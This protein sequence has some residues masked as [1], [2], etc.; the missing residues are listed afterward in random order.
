MTQDDMVEQI[1]Q[2]LASDKPIP[3]SLRNELILT[4]LISVSRVTKQLGADVQT[5]LNQIRAEV[6]DLRKTQQAEVAAVKVDIG[7]VKGEVKEV[8]ER[9]LVLWVQK[10]QRLAVALLLI[11]TVLANLWFDSGVLRSIVA[12]WLGIPL[13]LMLPQ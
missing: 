8:R 3:A 6:A 9:S 13:D 5:A 2:L 7:V 4:L 11:V 12:W 10:N 1:E